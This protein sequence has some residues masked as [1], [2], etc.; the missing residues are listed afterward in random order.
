MV[1]NEKVV[2]VLPVEDSAPD[3]PKR[4]VRV[5]PFHTD[6][7]TYSLRERSV[8]HDRRDCAHGQMVKED[9]NAVPGAVD[10]RR[11]DRCA[12]L[13]EGVDDMF[14]GDSGG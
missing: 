2:D 4:T 7:L 13:D 10:R 14:P 12:D 11:C 5:S 8:Y 9:G 6:S 3:N 1:S